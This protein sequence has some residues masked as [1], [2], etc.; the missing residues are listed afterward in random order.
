[1]DIQ[2]HQEM[3]GFEVTDVR[4]C[5]EFRGRAVNMVHRKT[6][7][8]LFWVDNG[9]ENMVFSIAF[10][11][12]PEDSTGVFHILEHSVLCG[13]SRYPV[14]EPFVELLKSS[15]STFLNA[16]T[17]PDMTMYPVA[18]RNPRD[19][20]NLTG[21]YL[22]AVFHPEVIRDEKRFCQEGWHIDRD[23]EGNPEYRGVVFN[24]MKGA[25][26]DTD[27][28][29]EHQLMKQ[30]FPDTSYGFNSGGDPEVIPDL[31]Y[32]KFREMY[33]RHYHPSNACI[34]LD[35][36][37]PLEE[38]LRLIG[39]YLDEYE[40]R[41]SRPEFRYQVP[42]AS[43]E[44]IRYELGEDEDEKN[45]GHWSLA[46]LTGTWRDKPDNMAMEIIGDVLTGS[47]EAPLKRAVLERELAQDLSITVDDSTLQS[48]IVIHA[49]NVTDGREAELEALIR[50]TG[51]DIR[52]NGLDRNAVEASMNRAVYHLREED[53]P[54][55]ISRC[56]RCTGEWIFGGDPLDA[57]Q[58]QELIRELKKML[59]DG[60]FN[61]L[62]AD[63]LLNREGAAILHTL[64]SRTLGAEKRRAEAERLRRITEGWTPEERKANGRLIEELDAWQKTPDSDEALATLPML[65]KEDADV[66]PEW[67]ETETEEC[68]GVTVLHHVIPANGVVHVRA[69]FALTDLNLEEITKAGLA[70]AMLGKLPTKHH[71]ALTLQQE[72]KRY[73]GTLGFSII[74][75]AFP[76]REDV[77]TP[78]LAASMSALAENA[79]KAQ[80]LMAEILTETLLDQPDRISEMVSQTE[81]SVRQKS[82]TAGTMFA[83]RQVTSQY[84]ADGAVKN[85]L[86]GAPA[87]AWIHRFAR[88]T[89]REMDDFRQLGERMIRQNICRKRMLISYTADEKQQPEAFI[90][91]FPEGTEA[92]ETAAYS[93][94]S[95]KAVGFRIPAQIGFAARGYRL[96]RCGMAFSGAMWLAAS[97]L[98]LGYLWNKVRVQGGAYGAGMQ[99]DRLG[100]LFSFSFRDPTPARTLTMDAG[101]S[102]F[103]KEFSK[104]EGEMDKYIISSLNELNP[105]LS[106]RDKGTA[107]DLRILSGYT[108]EMAEKTRKEILHATP[109]DLVACGEALDAFARDGSVCVVGHKDALDA[110]QLDV[111]EDL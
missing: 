91:C 105:L 62:A 56:I 37:V 87:A 88:E 66:T 19:L 79:E 85:A 108:R 99:T 44:T 31:T 97:I 32:E 48:W 53:E 54:Q 28:L 16:M 29:I 12:L 24:E 38:M 46:R 81:L 42:V 20:L 107:A 45:R 49:E 63:M 94:E 102:D 73:T 74:T 30:M 6:G 4:E 36:A 22:D 92:P 13:S 86:D 103:L 58:T 110:C 1:M 35:G 23:E 7:A 75:R 59:E 109:E 57:L 90:R 34:Y 68:L 21:V 27:N 84:S 10:R 39:G 5:S 82:L 89:D 55:G 51:E 98:S 8:E 80:E 26:S 71:D 76:D 83:V 47:N 100:N 67:T 14:K 15:M 18:S 41:E 104:Q 106:P 64:P 25:M 9:A 52:K 70:A 77:C 33:D 69:Y 11:T 95:R 93:A 78:Y 101:A 17:F 40:K 43:E 2:I 72:I 60:R 96:N 61:S 65:K 50:E 3:Y 111:V